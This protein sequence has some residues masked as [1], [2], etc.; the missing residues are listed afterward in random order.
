[1]GMID[2]EEAIK[3]A[4]YLKCG[5]VIR[6]DVKNEFYDLVMHALREKMHDGCDGCYWEGKLGREYPCNECKQNYMD[7]WTRWNTGAWKNIEDKAY[8]GGGATVC[9][10][11]GKGFAWG[12]YHEV[13]EWEYCP[14]CGK[15]M[16]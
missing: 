8:A 5:Y 16:R 10:Y 7:M 1:M 4:N 12:A 6:D 2:Y 14:N 9:T 3:I 15:K 11:C 13:D